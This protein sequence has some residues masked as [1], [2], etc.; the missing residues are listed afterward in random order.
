[1]L[2]VQCVFCS[3]AHELKR[4]RHPEH[5]GIPST[6]R[7]AGRRMCRRETQHRLIRKL[8]VAIWTL[9]SRPTSFALLLQL[10]TQTIPYLST[11][12]SNAFL[13]LDG[14]GAITLLIG[15]PSFEEALHVLQNISS[16]LSMPSRSRRS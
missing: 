3:L 13:C 6:E 14:N 7:L 10:L 4:V 2:H 15:L 12:L 16:R 1:M 5:L 11:P 9:E 8:K